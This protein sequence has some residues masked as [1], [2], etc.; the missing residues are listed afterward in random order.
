MLG[1]HRPETPYT[2]SYIKDQSRLASDVKRITHQTLL[3]PEQQ[4]P[5]QA[6]RLR[7][8]ADARVFLVVAPGNLK[9]D[10]G[11]G[12]SGHV[13][14]LLINVQQAAG[15]QPP[16]ETKSEHSILGQHAVSHR[17]TTSGK[18]VQILVVDLA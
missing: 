8:K 14:G 7:L 2:T 10:G 12:L 17:A 5:G 6:R 9:F 4:T 15:R 16:R 13:Q 1:Q 11:W 18:H 3:T